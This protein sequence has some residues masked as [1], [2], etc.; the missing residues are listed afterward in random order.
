MG[1]NYRGSAPLRV[2]S[3]NPGGGGQMRG[4]WKGEKKASNWCQETNK[5]EKHER[6]AGRIKLLCLQSSYSC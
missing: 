3:K 5:E 4:E 1:E 2:S 6:V